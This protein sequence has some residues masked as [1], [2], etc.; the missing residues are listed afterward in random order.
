[1]TEAATAASRAVNFAPHELKAVICHAVALMKIGARDA[2]LDALLNSNPFQSKLGWN[3]KT[4]LRHLVEAEEFDLAKA[5]VEAAVQ[6]PGLLLFGRPLITSVLDEEAV[7]RLLAD[8]EPGSP[9]IRRRLDEWHYLGSILA[10]RGMHG[11]AADVCAH[12]VSIDSGN[13][14]LRMQLMRELQKAGRIEAAISAGAETEE[15]PLTLQQYRMLATIYRDLR[16]WLGVERVVSHILATH[17][18]FFDLR[19]LAI[20]ACFDLGDLA[21]VEAHLEEAAALSADR[22]NILMP[23]ARFYSRLA[24]A[25]ERAPQQPG[26]PAQARDV[27]H[28]RETARAFALR[29]VSLEPSSVMNRM[30]FARAQLDAND[31]GAAADTLDFILLNLEPTDAAQWISIAELYEN[32]A[33]PDGAITAARYAVRGARRAN[34]HYF[35]VGRTLLRNGQRDEARGVLGKLELSRL[36]QNELSVFRET[37]ARF[38]LVDEFESADSGR[39]AI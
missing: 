1:L 39:V 24:A 7:R 18:D 25:F 29:A 34:W 9:E 28:R 3:Q 22:A 35:L 38:A 6:V 27:V 36:N 12:T 31:P 4:L 8:T 21:R 16:H 2:A 13:V 37:L 14:S 20:E 11:V 17:P 32:A 26:H 30:V 33:R 23:I 5:L 19:S 15:L 10:K